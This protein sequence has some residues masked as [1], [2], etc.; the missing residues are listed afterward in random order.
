MVMTKRRV[1]TR[2]LRTMMSMGG[3]VALAGALGCGP[4][5]SA[6]A[7]DVED[8]VASLES[9]LA[10]APGVAT[11]TRDNGGK[12][13]PICWMRAGTYPFGGTARTWTNEKATMSAAVVKTW[14]RVANVRF[15]WSSSFCP[16][17]GLS[18]Y[19]R[20]SLLGKTSGGN[21]D[22]NGWDGGT[23]RPP[24]GVGTLHPAVPW[25]ASN[26]IAGDSV[27]I[28]LR[29]D[30]VAE[31]TAGRMQAV[32]VHEFGHVLGFMH[33]QARDDNNGQCTAGGD[34]ILSG[35]SKLTAFDKYSIMSYCAPTERYTLTTLDVLGARKA[36]GYR[37]A[38]DMVAADQWRDLL[39]RNKTNGQVVYWGMS[40][41]TPT[42]TST[43]GTITVPGADWA[44]VGTADF[45]NDGEADLLWHNRVAGVGQIWLMSGTTA[46]PFPPAF[47]TGVETD[48]YL[49]TAGDFDGDGNPDIVWQHPSSGTSRIWLMKD[50][51]K[52]SAPA[53]FVTG[54]TGWKIV[55]AADYN[56]D[57]K[58]DLVWFNPASNGQL[59]ISYMNGASVTL[60][61]PAFTNIGAGWEPQAVGD[62]DGDYVPDIV[63]THTP[64][65][66]RSMWFMSSAI[67]IKSTP[68]VFTTVGNDWDIVGP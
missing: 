52:L 17:S 40:S 60:W 22:G 44:V 39:W 1:R 48:W 6:G 45:N 20:V 29:Q 53:A 56:N 33:E 50:G 2:W 13:I 8:P 54:K 43:Q 49:R 31:T 14:G 47:A 58:D 35:A 37:N 24:L 9:A 11:W 67:A 46:L 66:Q 36:Y 16:T 30:N 7:E 25:S 5:E 28:V 61:N 27:N 21:T 62:Y 10:V 19:V 38:G 65:G 55:G 63:W 3:A 41:G 12:T 15:S 26:P 4:V 23:T 57:G 51:V 32:A 42:G 59:Q 68:P 18:Y 64:S 34:P